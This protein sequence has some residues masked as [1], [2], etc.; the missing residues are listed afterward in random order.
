MKTA[1]IAGVCLLALAVT[2]TDTLQKKLI[3]C[4]NLDGDVKTCVDAAMATPVDKDTVCTSRCKSAQAEYAKICGSDEFNKDYD[5]EC[6][7]R[8][9]AAGNVVTLFALV[10]AVLVAV[11]N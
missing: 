6:Y 5:K 8:L 1:L 2:V 11:G 10:S 3:D 4:N 7:S 9:S